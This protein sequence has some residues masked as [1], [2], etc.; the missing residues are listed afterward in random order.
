MSQSIE[1]SEAIAFFDALRRREST[2][3]FWSYDRSN[4]QERLTEAFVNDVSIVFLE[5]EPRNGD[6]ILVE[7]F[8]VDFVKLDRDEAPF[9]ISDIAPESYDYVLG[10]AAGKYGIC[11]MAKDPRDEAAPTPPALPS[12]PEG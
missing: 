8:G 10:F 5:I 1:A 4:G 12:T 7:I 6:T 9:Q 2:L 3:V 11:I